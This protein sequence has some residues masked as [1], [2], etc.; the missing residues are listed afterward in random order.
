MEDPECRAGG[1]EPA[2]PIHHINAIEPRS[3]AARRPRRIGEDLQKRLPLQVQIRS[4]ISHRR[5][6]RSVAEPLTDR[7]EID[8]CLEQVNGRRVSECVRVNASAPQRCYCLG[9]LTDPL[10]E[11]RID[12]EAG[13]LLPAQVQK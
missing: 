12:S 11:E 8:S 4:G 2:Q 10:L 7:G 9:T 5:V 6:E 13:E 3:A 1:L